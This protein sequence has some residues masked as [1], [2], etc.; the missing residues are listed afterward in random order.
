MS[1]VKKQ[2]SINDFH[3]SLHVLAQKLNKKDYDLVSGVM[4]RLY[5]GIKFDY[6]AEFDPNVM[7]DIKM[8]WNNFKE[9]KIKRKAKVLKFKLIQGR[10]DV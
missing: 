5:M 9:K 6:M 2:P 3:K 7:H 4:F 8:I 1:V 10:K